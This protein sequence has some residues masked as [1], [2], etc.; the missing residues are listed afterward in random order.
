MENYPQIHNQ[1]KQPMALAFIT[2]ITHGIEINKWS[3]MSECSTYD[4]IMKLWYDCDMIQYVSSQ[5]QQFRQTENSMEV[6]V[7]SLWN[8][9]MHYKELWISE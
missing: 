8:T 5:T 4:I 7:S 1:T 6:L 3:I 9:N 2:N